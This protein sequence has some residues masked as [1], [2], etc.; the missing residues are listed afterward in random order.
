MPNIASSV[1]DM[2]PNYLQTVAAAGLHVLLST[3]MIGDDVIK[4]AEDCT[5]PTK[6]RHHQI[7][8]ALCHTLVD[9]Y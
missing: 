5:Y 6:Q 7:L 9:K 2:P 4:F 1:T 8:P 3:G